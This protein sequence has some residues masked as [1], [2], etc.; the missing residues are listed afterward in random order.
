[1]IAC[2][3]RNGSGAGSAGRW[4]R[5]QAVRAQGAFGQCS[6]SSGLHFGGLVW[7]E[8]LDLV[9]FVGPVQ[10]WLFSGSVS[11]G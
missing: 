4:S 1:M 7:G 5:Q 8:E 2:A 6:R 9:A 10:L 11:R 3:V